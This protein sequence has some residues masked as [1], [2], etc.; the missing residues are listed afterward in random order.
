GHLSPLSAASLVDSHSC[1]SL[2]KPCN[3][4]ISGCRPVEPAVVGVGKLKSMSSG[5]PSK[6]GT[7]A[8]HTR[9]PP[10]SA[11]ETFV[12]MGSGAAAAASD[13]GGSNAS[14]MPIDARRGRKLM[15]LGALAAG[16]PA[17]A[18]RNNKAHTWPS[19]RRP[20]T[21]TDW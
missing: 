6:L 2:P 11:H 10:Y 3:N 17:P 1:L 14:T 5:V 7:S 20:A 9:T 19:L 15:A 16:V 18:R 12:G 21:T 4:T 13:D 8:E